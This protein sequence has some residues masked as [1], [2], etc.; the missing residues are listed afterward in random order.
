MIDLTEEMEVDARRAIERYDGTKLP[1]LGKAA[2]ELEA[3]IKQAEERAKE[4]KKELEALTRY[5]I[6]NAL[7]EAGV[8]EFGFD[9]EGGRARMKLDVKVVGSL[10]RAVDEEEAVRYLEANGFSGAV[11]SVV[12][13]DFTEQERELAETV[14]ERLLQWGEPHMA[15]KIAPQT[16]MAFVRAKLKEDPSF[17]F[18]KVGMTAFTEAKFTVRS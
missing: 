17:D 6:P 10:S 13:L 1:E 15:R 11:K 8:D 9:H 5:V 14:M 12:S 3:E 18:E 7:T 4:L 2:L 16:L